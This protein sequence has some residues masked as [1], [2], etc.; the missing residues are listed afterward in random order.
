V[1]VN[2]ED[3]RGLLE[4][5]VDG[6]FNEVVDGLADNIA[7]KLL[8]DEMFTDVVGSWEVEELI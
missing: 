1:E 8:V 7:G 2:E 6:M 3:V 5:V 4:E